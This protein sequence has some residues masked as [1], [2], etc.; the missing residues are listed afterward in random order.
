MPTTTLSVTDEFRMI[1]DQGSEW[2]DYF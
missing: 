1:G 2:S